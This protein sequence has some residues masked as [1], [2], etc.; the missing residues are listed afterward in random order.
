MRPLAL[1]KNLKVWQKLAFLS[2]VLIIPIVV[3][4]FLFINAA[5]DNISFA[6]RE[7]A[8]LKVINEA[9]A[10]TRELNALRD[11]AG[12]SFG[13]KATDEE[14]KAAENA[15]DERVNKINELDRQS[16]TLLGT[17]EKWNKFK[18]DYAKLKSTRSFGAPEA[19]YDRYTTLVADS[20]AVVTEAGIGSYLILDPI[21]TTYLLQDNVG[22][23][24]PSAVELMARLRATTARAL[25]AKSDDAKERN[26]LG[27]QLGQVTHALDLVK[28]NVD[29]LKD[30]NKAIYGELADKFTETAQQLDSYLAMLQSELLGAAAKP[31]TGRLVNAGVTAEQALSRFGDAQAPVLERL[32]TARSAGDSSRLTVAIIVLV[33]SLTLTLMLVYLLTNSINEQVSSIAGLFEKISTGDFNARADVYAEDELGEMATSLNSMLD[34]T[35]ALIQSR[36]D[37]DQIQR[38]ITRLLEEVSGVADGDLTTEAEVTA[39]ITGAI[40]DSF[41]YM[42]GQLRTVIGDVQ[43]ATLQVNAFA[44]EI[45]TSAHDLT[46]RSET[47]AEQIVST[48]A[49]VDDMTRSIQQVSQSASLSASVAEQSLANARQGNN[50]V[51]NTIAGMDRI[52][53]QVQETAKRIKRLGESSQ[54]IGQII[55]LIDDIADRTSILALNASIQASMAGEAGRGFAVVAEEVERLADRSTEATKKIAGL[56]KTIQS[57]TNEAVGAMEKGI[58]EVIEG[59][60][61][62]SQAGQAL[63]EIESVSNKLADLIQSISTTSKQQAHASEGVSKSM[64]EISEITQQTAAGTKQATEAVNAL[65]GLAERLRASVVS[66]RLPGGGMSQDAMYLSPASV[67]GIDLG[68]MNG[69]RSGIRGKPETARY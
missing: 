35:Q 36:E 49:A 5:T 55:Q 41:N 65:A 32:L 24:I 67:S 14:L 42:I 10:L 34:N 30:K 60:K 57:E 33:I 58:Q 59:S 46:A 48:S 15:I 29:T 51:K 54:E 69:N 61:L 21:L 63:G 6:S 38:S 62:A 7:L 16:G 12:Q 56:V 18:D 64:A 37:R 13:R 28:S 22:V 23:R 68:S 50:A 11:L 45:Y 40:A 27:I 66:F 19:A 1:L 31:E 8:G 25:A 53:D 20:I 9:N 3:L 52:R 26:L 47:Q 4:A 17:T 43:K 2:G 39:D 44:T